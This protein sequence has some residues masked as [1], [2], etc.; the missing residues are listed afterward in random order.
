MGPQAHVEYVVQPRES[1]WAVSCGGEPIGRFPTRHDALRVALGDADHVGRLGHDIEVFVQAGS[2]ET[3]GA[4]SYSK[5]RQCMVR[6]RTVSCDV[7]P[8]RGET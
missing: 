5:D 1:G 2:G 6:R 3:M 7:P 8:G 4:W